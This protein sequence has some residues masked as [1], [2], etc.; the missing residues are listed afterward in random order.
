MVLF[1]YVGQLSKWELKKPRVVLCILDHLEA[2][3]GQAYLTSP[4]Q[5]FV[6]WG[7]HVTYLKYSCGSFAITLLYCL[8]YRPLY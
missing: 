3:N 1:H 4:I 2:F 8:E 6:K 7:Y 5:A